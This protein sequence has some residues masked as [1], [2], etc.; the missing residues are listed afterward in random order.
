MEKIER[1]GIA[2]NLRAIGGVMCAASG[3][4]NLTHHKWVALGAACVAVTL[5]VWSGLRVRANRIKQL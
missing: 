4:A 3:V 1:D 5:L 2:V